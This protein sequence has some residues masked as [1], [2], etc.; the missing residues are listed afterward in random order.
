MK[1]EISKKQHFFTRK[2]LEWHEKFNNRAMPWKYEKD[3][4]KI[5]I[6]E[7]ILQQT[8]VEQGLEYYNRFIKKFP[9]V[10]KLAVAKEEEVFKLWEGLGYYSRCRNLISTAQFIAT[11]RKGI[12]PD[13]HEDIL[14]LKGIGP[15]TA[16][17][18]ASFAFQLPYAVVDGNVMR[19]LS[20]FFAIDTPIDSVAGKKIFNELAQSLLKKENPG[21]YNQAIMDLGA[22][23]CKP[24]SP[25]CNQC[26]LSAQ[27]AAFKSKTWEDFPVKGKKLKIKERWFYYLI[28]ELND[29]FYTRSRTGKDIW[30]QLQEFI[31][32]ES[33]TPIS[34]NQLFKSKTFKDIITDKFQHISTSASAMQ[35]LTHQ[36]I[37]GTFIHLKLEKPIPDVSYSLKRKAELKKLAFPKLIAAHIS[38]K[39]LF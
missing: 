35:K 19:V 20:R 34:D 28:A 5:W 25:L 12:F 32:I 7:I 13:T 22:T 39:K 36:H 6:S 31:L 38:E 17:A 30:Q 11:K 27:C 18:I 26:L 10:L 8:R 33:E 3:P 15:Y 4:Y 1:D 29:K 2:L 21:I 24:R 23:I 37:H 16:A 9:N 14:S